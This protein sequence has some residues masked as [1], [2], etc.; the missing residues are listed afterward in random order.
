[1]RNAVNP[2]QL[3]SNYFLPASAFCGYLFCM[4]GFSVIFTVK[5]DYLL[6]QR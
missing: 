2:L 4:Y 3:N 1:M 5:R 6:K